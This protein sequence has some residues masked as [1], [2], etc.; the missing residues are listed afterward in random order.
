MNIRRIFRQEVEGYIGVELTHNCRGSLFFADHGVGS[1]AAD[2]VE[3][4]QLAIFPEYQ[5]KRKI[6]ELK[7]KVVA[8]L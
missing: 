3:C 8:G 4:S 5:E 1:V 2:V 6:C 7:R